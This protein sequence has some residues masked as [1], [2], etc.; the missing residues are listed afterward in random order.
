MLAF[1]ESVITMDMSLLQFLR[2]NTGFQMVLFIFCVDQAAYNGLAFK[3]LLCLQLLLL[4]AINFFLWMEPRGLHQGV[5]ALLGHLNR[6]DN[7]KLLR[8][9]SRVL[10][11]G[12]NHDKVC[13]VIPRMAEFKADFRMGPPPYVDPS[14]SAE[15]KLLLLLDLML[16][17][18]RQQN[19]GATDPMKA[20]D[21]SRRKFHLNALLGLLNFTLFGDKFIH[22]CSG[23][24]CCPR[25]AEEFKE[26]LSYH[27]VMITDEGIDSW[28]PTRFTKIYGTP[29]YVTALQCI[30]F[31]GATSFSVAFKKNVED[32]I[33]TIR[34][35]KDVPNDPL[36]D[37]NWTANRIPRLCPYLA[38]RNLSTSLMLRNFLQK[39]CRIRFSI[40]RP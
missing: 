39:A 27:M 37:I 29:S 25:G 40:S 38:N 36:A 30:C 17:N 31:F 14:A 18:T 20:T 34:S 12:K 15:C 24:G 8:S 10:R 22:Y 19:L 26:K 32:A 23:N 6:C 11:Q 4:P 16:L 5:R 9:C 2:D 13:D 7:K 28:V 35:A 21:E 33:E 1:I 3:F